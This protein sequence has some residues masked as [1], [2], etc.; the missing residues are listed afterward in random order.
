MCVLLPTVVTDALLLRIRV[1]GLA[2]CV[3]SI[4]LGTQN[5]WDESVLVAATGL[6]QLLLLLELSLEQC[7]Q[8]KEVPVLLLGDCG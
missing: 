4:C 7:M 1:P 2:A 8:L 6:H 3:Y 5:N